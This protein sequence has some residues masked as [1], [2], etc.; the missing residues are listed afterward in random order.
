MATSAT[1]T[2]GFEYVLGRK[3][4]V[5]GSG[6]EYIDASKS[7]TLAA[8]FEYEADPAETTQAI[9]SRITP[10]V[11]H[12]GQSSAVVNQI[13]AE[14]L[15]SVYSEAVISRISLEVLSSNQVASTRL[16]PITFLI[17]D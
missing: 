13:K 2:Q 11:L 7:Y 10:E 16:R 12:T 5:L 6:F 17:L 15:S 4:A 9:V 14:V 1:L 8:G 3:W